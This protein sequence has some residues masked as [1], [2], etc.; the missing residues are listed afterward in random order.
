MMAKQ[1]E[2]K[3]IAVL[4]RIFEIPIGEDSFQFQVHP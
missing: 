3:A 2:I 4:H 1:I